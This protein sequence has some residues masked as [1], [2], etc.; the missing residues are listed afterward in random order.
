MG[1]EGSNDWAW[2][3]AEAEPTE[4]KP[5]LVDSCLTPPPI[6]RWAG[7]VSVSTRWVCTVMM[8]N[9]RAYAGGQPDSTT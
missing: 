1:K 4:S 2:D 8:H 3:T 9:R 6:S 7:C 5:R